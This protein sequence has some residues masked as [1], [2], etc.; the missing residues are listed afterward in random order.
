MERLSYCFQ[1]VCSTCN[2]LQLIGWRSSLEMKVMVSRELARKPSLIVTKNSNKRHSHLSSSP[3]AIRRDALF[4]RIS[5]RSSPLN[6]KRL[7]RKKRPASEAS[8]LTRTVRMQR[9]ET[10]V[11]HPQSRLNPTRASS[12]SGRCRNHGK[13]AAFLI[14]YWGTTEHWCLSISMMHN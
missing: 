5:D 2:V 12:A 10:A 4:S 14:K 7:A 11:D 9:R 13:N 3:P 8:V 1:L 6:R